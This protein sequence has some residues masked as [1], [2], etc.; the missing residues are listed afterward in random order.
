MLIFNVGFVNENDERD[1][2]QLDVNEYNSEDAE[3]I[4][5]MNLI[6]SLK[7]EMGIKQ[8]ISIDCVGCDDEEEY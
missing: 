1:E 8:V 3:I 4:E 2:T 5:L 7:D 6:L